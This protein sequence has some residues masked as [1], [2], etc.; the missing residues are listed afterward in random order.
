MLRKFPPEDGRIKLAKVDCTVEGILCR[1]HHIQGFPSI[2]VFR[3]GD[4]PKRY[5]RRLVR[6]HPEPM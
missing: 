6:T 2:R 4:S 5:A 1:S 3:S